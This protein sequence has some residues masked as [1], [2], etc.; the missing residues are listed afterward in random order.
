MKLRPA[1][2]ILL[3]ALASVAPAAETLDT[4]VCIYGAT[5]AGVM[6]AVQVAREGKQVVLLEPGTYAGGISVDGLGGT[7]IDNHKEFKN[8]AAVGG[9]ASEFYRRIGKAYGKDGWG[10]R[11]EPHI[12]QRVVDGLL[13]EHG[14]KP[15]LRERL[16]LGKDGLEKT[17]TR[18]SAI[19]MESG[20]T[21]RAKVFIDATIE[22][23]LLHVAGVSTIIGR[24]PNARY[25]ETKNGIRGENTYRQFS[26]KVDPYRIPGDPTSGLIPTVQD[27]PFGTPGDGDHRLQGFC[28]R[29]C[30]TKVPENRVAFTKP[31]GYDPAQYEI[32]LRYLKAGGKLFSPGANLPNGKTDLGSWH[33]LSLNLYGMN[34]EYPGGD[35]VTRERVVRFHRVFSQGLCYFLANDPAVPDATRAVWSQWGTCKDEFQDNQGWPRMFYV[36]DA[37]RM[38]SDYV[39]TEHHTRKT[40]QTRVEDPV[41]VAYWPPDTHH[42]RRIVK[43]GYCYNEGFVFGGDDWAPFGI[44]YRA[45]VPKASECTNLLAGSCPSSTHVAYGAIRLE[46]TFMAMGQACGSAAVIAVRDGLDVQRVP[47]ATL[48]QRLLADKQVVELPA[49]K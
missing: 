32:Y 38:V 11:F 42:V 41:C 23:D 1:L 7:D 45:L 15:R 44:S 9:L 10:L 47:Y 3:A 46:W 14:V 37:R 20:L 18:L 8:G 19:R 34:Y 48:K 17:G 12:A 49:A 28:F 24:E 30:F 22:G 36:R 29:F 27:E 40:N 6:A 31:D 39:I 16:I 13:A 4:D 25:G 26:V 21:V 2:L 33:D 43:D 35:Y 5:A